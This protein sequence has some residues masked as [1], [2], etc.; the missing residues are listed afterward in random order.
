[1]TRTRIKIC[2]ITNIRDAAFAVASE[3]DALGFVLY[4]KSSRYV[5]VETVARIIDQ[6]PPY[7]T[8][9]ALLVNHS[10][11]D[12][13]RLLK[14]AAF[15]LLQFH[16]DE[17]DEFCISFGMPF[18]K[19]I[20][21]ERSSELEEQVAGYPHSKGILLDAFVE[22][23]YGGTGKTI[24]WPGVSGIDKPVVLAGGLTPDNV[25][26]AIE[27]VRPFAVDVSGGVESEK[28][29]KDHKKISSFIRAVRVADS[30]V[31]NGR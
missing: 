6:L 2:G 15:D 13:S 23:E 30:G 1:M 17:T 11:E 27:Q 19:A 22:G 31:N 20:R 7:V 24:D 25:G 28:G 12:V 16:G 5:N 29:V 4:E 8:T 21:V 9:V 3:A 26:Q 18:I 14:E 10:S